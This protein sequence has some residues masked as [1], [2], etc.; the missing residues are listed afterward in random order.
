M[1]NNSDN[2]IKILVFTL[3]YYP[4]IGG[5]EIALQE[6]AKR[7]R[8]RFEFEVITYKFD[9]A[10]PDFEFIDGIPVHRVPG[11]ILGKYS[12]FWQ[13]LRLADRLHRKNNYRIVWGMMGSHGGL[14]AWLFKRR[15]FQVKYLLT[16]QS[17]DSHL[18]WLIRTWWWRPWF[19]RIYKEADFIQV[20]SSH[21]AKL[22]R[23]YGYQGELKV[24]PNGIADNWLKAADHQLELA[25]PDVPAGSKVV[26]SVSRLVKKN[27][28][29]DL[30]RSLLF[31]PAEY[32]LVIIG[33][34]PERR[35]L[36][37][38]SRRLGISERVHLLG[39]VPYARLPRYYAV[40]DVFCRPSLSEGLGNVFL[41]AMAMD[42]PVVATPV[43]GIVD[44]VKD[45]ETGL[46]ARVSDAR[47]I[48]AKIRMAV[49]N[50][51]LRNKIV[52][53]AGEMVKSSYTWEKV[54][55]QMSQ[56]FIKLAG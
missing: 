19:K 27:G 7:L 45:E 50:S 36:E 31:L 24:V 18:F 3:A 55:E 25:L 21:L 52:S 37:R 22:V 13:A 49:E 47:D 12:Y 39:S 35:R 15:F 43:G 34:G 14:A 56:I 53:R 6:I 4:Y 29:K 17:G 20:I 46:L 48:A 41:E 5:A 28:L 2:K 40:A 51:D 54:A 16:E 23:G 1:N 44:I 10:L 38:L 32:H 42:L 11:K 9:R 26:L 33:E 30:I 8:E